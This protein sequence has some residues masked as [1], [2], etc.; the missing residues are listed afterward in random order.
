MIDLELNPEGGWNIIYNGR[1][2]GNS[3]IATIHQ[4]KDVCMKLLPLF[5]AIY[6]RTISSVTHQLETAEELAAA[7]LPIHVDELYY[8]VRNERIDVSVRSIQS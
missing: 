7:G 8:V 4:P 5:A 6:F 1:D 3:L 2:R